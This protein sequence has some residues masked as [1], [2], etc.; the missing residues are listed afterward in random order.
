MVQI[1]KKCF[2]N[3]FFKICCFYLIFSCIMALIDLF[4]SL[5]ISCWMLIIDPF[6]FSIT[7]ISFLIKFLDF[8]LANYF[9]GF[10]PCL[11]ILFF[12]H[13][14]SFEAFLL[15]REIFLNISWVW[16]NFPSYFPEQI[17][18]TQCVAIDKLC[19]IIRF[20]GC[21][22]SIIQKTGVMVFF[23]YV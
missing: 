22:V 11:Y 23:K 3:F 12:S 13:F 21:I 20:W 1:L 8:E 19:I 10:F 4:V 14:F 17:I 7:N 15:C 5:K 2:Q 16:N 6:S 18:R 9:I